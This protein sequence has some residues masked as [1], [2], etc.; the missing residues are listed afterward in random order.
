MGLVAL[1]GLLYFVGSFLAFLSFYLREVCSALPG[2]VS[3]ECVQEL[4]DETLTAAGWDST[5]IAISAVLM[6]VAAVLTL[7]RAVSALRSAAWVDPVT[8]GL[9]G[10]A[11]LFTVVVLGFLDA[12]GLS[13]ALAVDLFDEL[14]AQTGTVIDDVPLPGLGLGG[15]FCLV[16]LVLALGG[17]ILTRLQASRA[18]RARRSGPSATGQAAPAGPPPPSAP[19]W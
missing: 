11:A 17:V 9:V 1:G 19:G 7:L 6:L 4:P 18:D 3:V 14:A 15:W 10:L 16:A 13:A 5:L 2:D 12:T 8:A